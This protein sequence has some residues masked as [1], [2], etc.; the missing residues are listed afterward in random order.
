MYIFRSNGSGGNYGKDVV[1]T[2]KLYKDLAGLENVKL[3]LYENGRHEMLNE[4]NKNEV[5]KDVLEWLE[6]II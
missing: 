6:D 4:V 3:K 5:Y 1:E 2:Y